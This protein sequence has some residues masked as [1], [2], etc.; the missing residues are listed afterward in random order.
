MFGA[1]LLRFPGCPEHPV[2]DYGRNDRLSQRVTHEPAH[3]KR[4]EIAST[5]LP[6]GCTAES[7]NGRDQYDSEGNENRYVPY[8]FEPERTIKEPAQNQR[9]SHSLH[10]IDPESR[11]LEPQGNI[12][13]AL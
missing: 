1:E 11:N 8:G 2:K 10:G 9:G 6:C 5:H 12:C 4:P 13:G 3:P 7:R